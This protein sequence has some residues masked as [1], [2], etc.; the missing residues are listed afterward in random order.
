MLDWLAEGV[1]DYLLLP[2]DDT[3][4]YGWNIAEAR[5]LQGKIR[6]L[7]LSDRAIVYPGADEIGCLLLAS[8]LCQQAG[9]KPS[10]W[11]RYSSIHS[12]NIITRYEDRPI[13]ELLKAHLA[14]LNGVVAASPES[15]DLLLFV[16]APSQAQGEGMYQ[17]LVWRDL[18]TL[19]QASLQGSSEETRPYQ[20]WIAVDNGFQATRHEM[21][22]PH[23]SPEEF[24]RALWSELPT[25]RPVALADVAFV[26]GADFILRNLLVKNPQIAHLSAYGGW[27]TAGNALG[28]V[29]AQAVLRTLALKNGAQPSQTKAH[30]EFLFLRFLDDYY[31]QARERTLA[32]LEDLPCL[33]LPSLWEYIADSTRASALNDRILSRLTQAA[34]ELEQIFIRSGL[35]SRVRVNNIHLPWQH[36]FEVSCDV[37]VTLASD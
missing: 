9:Y 20:E 18:E 7:G 29:L 37:E 15:A 11:P 24:V 13:Q 12:A 16:N 17:W 6:A 31:Y 10:L 4:D 3:A 36:L 14:P 22:T 5:A 33:G 28:C 25:G 8:A 26:N 34:I 30:L 21:E 23:R 2:Q 1:F 19:P 35:V 32:W 27:N